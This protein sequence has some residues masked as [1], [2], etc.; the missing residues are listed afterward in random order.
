MDFASLRHL[1]T[2]MAHID[3][4]VHQ[5]VERA[6]A[7]GRDPTDALRGL[8]ISEDEV[9]THLSREAL[10]GLWPADSESAVPLTPF[11]PDPHLPFNRLAH[12]FGL[13]LLDCYIL[14]LVLAPELDRR[15]E[16]LYAYLQDDVSQRRP[17]VNL[18]M[19]MLG[20]DVPA[21][22]AVWECLKPQMPLRAHHLIECL[23]NPNHYEPAFIAYQLK[24]DH[25]ILAE[26]LGD[27]TPD[28]RLDDAV[29]RF[30]PDLAPPPQTLDL[31]SLTRALAEAP[32]V[33][34]QGAAGTGR[35]ATAAQLCDP[36]VQVDL[37]RLQSLP[38]PFELAW[39][40]AIRE[41]R[42]VGG[43]LLLDNWESC[44]E[45]DGQPPAKLWDALL[46]FAHTVFI[47]GAEDWEPYNTLRQRRLLR[48]RFELPDFNERQ[49]LWQQYLPDAEPDGLE[50]LAGKF[51]FTSGQIARAVNTA[52]DLAESRAEPISLADLYAGAQAHSSL[53][54]GDMARRIVPRYDW[55]DL[56][57]PP[58]P[59][60]QLR[61]IRE[62]AQ[63]AH[64]VH[65]EWGYGA[66]VAPTTGVS[67]LFAGESGTGK[68]M[69]AEVIASDL[70]LVLYKIDLSTVV[71]KYI[72]ETEKN[73]ECDLRRGAG[74]QRHPLLRRSRRAS[75]ANAPKS[76]TPTTAT[77]TSRS[78]TCCSASKRTMASPS[79]RP[80]CART[81]TKP[82]PAASIL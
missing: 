14:L 12:I 3:G 1:Q 58:D 20:H 6:Q 21:R 25:R 44:L 39:Q 47:C 28:V 18:M 41:A 54:L 27:S 11:D 76:R 63:Y 79:W 57:L 22:Y 37:A 35:R 10:A 51:R 43:A 56:V 34:L 38:I 19:N 46:A 73:L 24:V 30:N 68:T 60:A 82:L 4:L 31:I 36:L 29:T 32:M 80:T 69:S 59:L 40:L 50:E 13:S 70:G 5:A 45:E 33:Y 78:P 26:L 15:Y 55:A 81:W 65:D 9:A 49:R 74:Q 67:A 17:T 23:P 66:K 64:R 2:S 42:L 72:G 62:R 7:A 48:F 52:A 71:S 53:R 75:S 8:I 16:R 77:P 61:E